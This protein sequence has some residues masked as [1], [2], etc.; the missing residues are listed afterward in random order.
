MKKILVFAA[1]YDFMAVFL[2]GSAL[3]IFHG[4]QHA[5]WAGVSM[6]IYS[7]IWIIFIVAVCESLRLCFISIPRALRSQRGAS[8]APPRDFGQIL[9]AWGVTE[10]SLPAVLRGLRLQRISL[11][12]LVLVGVVL[13][14][15]SD[16]MVRV[17]IPGGIMALASC[18]GT[19]VLTWR[20]RVLEAGRYVSFQEW[21]TRRRSLR[22]EG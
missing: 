21:I 13:V 16:G 11:I 4:F 7:I 9:Q 17:W 6:I 8:S 5:I 10:E 19:V 15:R 14:A 1:R 3:G 22:E 12:I 2:L 18:F 20:L